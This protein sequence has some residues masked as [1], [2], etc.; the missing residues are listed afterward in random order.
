M[1]TPEFFNRKR[2]KNPE[3]VRF[4]VYTGE[5]QKK[6]LFKAE[7]FYAE[8]FAKVQDGS[9]TQKER[10]AVKG[11]LDTH[12]PRQDDSDCEHSDT[13]NDSD[14]EKLSDFVF[15]LGDDCLKRHKNDGAVN[16]ATFINLSTPATVLSITAAAGFFEDEECETKVDDDTSEPYPRP[17]QVVVQ[18]TM[19]SC[20]VTIPGHQ[21]TRKT[22]DYLF[23][24]M[25]DHVYK[26]GKLY[27]KK[28]KSVITCSNEEIWKFQAM[29]QF[30]LSF[31]EP[32]TVRIT[33]VY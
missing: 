22:F 7:P 27:N 15:T 1:T 31:K 6:T 19:T 17:F 16:P 29:L 21:V 24:F 32:Q 30:V 2:K 26:N 3:E 5:P 18:D 33:S 9:A 23:T 12:P 25:A 10:K 11:L 20:T 13:E 8:L 4:T 14:D 28:N